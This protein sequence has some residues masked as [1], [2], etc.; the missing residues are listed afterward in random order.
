[1]AATPE[2]SAKR[3]MVLVW[4]FMEY[5]ASEP[6][7]LL[8]PEELPEGEEDPPRFGYQ[9]ICIIKGGK[10]NSP[11]PEPEGEAEGSLKL[12]PLVTVLVDWQLLELGVKATLDGVTRSPT[13]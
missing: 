13:V 5:A 8:L 3:V 1:M 4:E 12:I 7:P 6:S 2:T 11:D 9:S 10:L